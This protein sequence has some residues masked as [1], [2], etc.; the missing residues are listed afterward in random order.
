MTPDLRYVPVS[1]FLGLGCTPDK[2]P[3]SETGSPE[4]GESLVPVECMALPQ[5]R[6][7]VRYVMADAPA[8]GDGSA[9]HPFSTP[10]EALDAAE[11]DWEIRVGSGTYDHFSV[12]DPVNH[13]H[14]SILGCGPTP[15]ELRGGFGLL[16]GSAAAL[17]D[18]Q[19]ANFRIVSEIVSVQYGVDIELA[20][21]TIVDEERVIYG[22]QIVNSQVSMS[23]VTVE[24][25]TFYGVQVEG[26]TLVT[27][28]NIEIVEGTGGYGL[29][30]AESTVYT[31]GTMRIDTPEAQFG[32]FLH[33]SAVV[34]GA[35][36]DVGPTIADSV[37]VDG[38]TLELSGCKWT[39]NG[40]GEF[41]IS[42]WPSPAELTIDANSEIEI[43]GTGLTGIGLYEGTAAE[44]NGQVTI[45]APDALYGVG[46]WGNSAITLT[47]D[48]S[49]TIQNVG[50][51][52]LVDNSNAV[53]AGTMTV[54]S[55]W[56]DAIRVQ[57]GQVDQEGGLWTFSAI[58][59]E[60]PTDIGSC[61]LDVF[62]GS[63]YLNGMLAIDNIQY[64]GIRLQNGSQAASEL[65]IG[66]DAEVAMTDIVEQN[67]I[68]ASDARVESFG[69]VYIDT[70]GT[71]AVVVYGGELSQS[72]GTW[73]LYNAGWNGVR[74]YDAAVQLS[75]EVKIADIGRSGIKITGG[76]A[77]L[78][79]V[80]VRGA[81]G[82]AEY[83]G[84]GFLFW[85]LTES[86]SLE[87]FR[88]VDNADVG[89]YAVGVTGTL[90]NGNISGNV[91][92]IIQEDCGDYAELS[93]TETMI[94]G[95][96]DDDVYLCE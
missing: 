31:S 86:F 65:W 94:T 15:P 59:T 29:Y 80:S 89:V 9:D 30:V 22:L 75:G 2:T 44:I 54:A 61:G 69:N 63:I 37:R 88:S 11:P 68:L 73:E 53:S 21:L 52:L 13:K 17:E 5:T 7:E 18:V 93:I 81:S 58:G 1:I 24:N 27:S 67:G 12:S 71:D 82:D 38:G 60:D 35:R 23:E 4:V 85:Y 91:N 50:T 46:V 6:A 57:N 33:D 92:S 41:G 76:S 64:S 79:N 32:I 26:S 43:N 66:L 87:N 48:G 90:S 14:L 25:S 42:A 10:T 40:A 78:A 47:A 74:A 56:D 19:V 8:G 36:L 62:G 96:D 72:E 95:N 77:A 49:V 28:G 34:W 39:L 55:V 3:D 83:P 70:T 16:G 20:E 45:D 51:G 84:D